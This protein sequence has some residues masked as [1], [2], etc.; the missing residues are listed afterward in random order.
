MIVREGHVLVVTEVDAANRKLKAMWPDSEDGDTPSNWLFVLN[1]FGNYNMP[2]IND[3]VAV[4]FD[5]E[6]NQGWVIGIVLKDGD[7]PYSDEDIIGIK[8]S[9]AEIRI[10]KSTGEITVISSDKVNVQASEVTI[11]ASE[12]TL[13]GNLKVDGDADVGGKVDVTGGIKANGEIEG[14]DVKAGVIRLLTHKHPT[15]ATG[16]ASP[17]IP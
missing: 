12:V 14:S 5:E 4:L 8:I 15:A 16:P 17:P 1:W 9:T 10:K 11:D 13:T 7:S 6:F 2:E 3:Q